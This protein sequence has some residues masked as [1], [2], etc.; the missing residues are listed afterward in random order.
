GQAAGAGAGKIMLVMRRTMRL[1][2][3]LSKRGCAGP[4][5]AKAAW[6]VALAEEEAPW[7]APLKP[8]PVLWM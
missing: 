1:S 5:R 8:M 3:L 7:T 6:W 4:G 2:A